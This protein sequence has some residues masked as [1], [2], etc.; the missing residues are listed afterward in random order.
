MNKELMHTIQTGRVWDT[1]GGD[2]NPDESFRLLKACGFEAVDFSLSSYIPNKTIRAGK[3]YGFYDADL[4]TLLDYFRPVKEAA[5]KHGIAFAQAHGPY[6]LDVE[7]YPEVHEY[8]LGVVEK[9]LGICQMLECP[10]LVIHPM[11]IADKEEEIDRNMEMY[12]KLIPAAKK[13]GVMICLEN[14]F[15]TKN[16]HKIGGACSN[17]DDVCYYIDTLNKEAGETL[18]GFCYDVGHATLTGNDILRDL[19]KLGHR[20]TALHIHGNDAMKD[21]HGIPY[22][23][24]TTKHEFTVDWEAFLQGLR[25]IG[26]RGPL[27]L[28]CFGSFS[29]LPEE[30]VLPLL[31]YASAVCGYFRKRILE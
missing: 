22:L 10:M 5:D 9:M 2:K 13:Y 24:R 20:L 4:Q 8:L 12:R 25:E 17:M 18:F 30:L 19:K 6:P 15:I 14:M 27:N 16:V 26:Y 21:L 1:F 11:I 31:Q 29:R 28:E 23:V 3:P 7:E